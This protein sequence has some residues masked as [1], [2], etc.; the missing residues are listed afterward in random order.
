MERLFSR[1]GL[2]PKQPPHRFA[3]R[4]V[5]QGKKCREFGGNGYAKTWGMSATA[6]I[7]QSRQCDSG[8]LEVPGFDPAIR[9]AEHSIAL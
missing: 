2:L 9:S 6:G 4:G 1:I 3:V 5:R 7:D 8:N